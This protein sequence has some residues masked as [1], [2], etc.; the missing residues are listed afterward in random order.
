MPE[1][2][3]HYFE[4]DMQ[5]KNVAA[6]TN[7]KKNG[8]I[9]IQMPVWTP[10]SY[11]IREYPKNVEGFTATAGGKPVPHE[12]IRKNAWRVYTGDDNLTVHYRV[13]ANDLTVRTS[14]VDADH[15]YVTPA[16]MFMYHE[17]LKTIPLRLVVQPYK[18]WKNVATGLEPVAGQ[19]FTYEA[20]NY[21]ILVDSPLEIGNQKTFTF[22]AA[23]VP[24]TVAMFGEA[25]L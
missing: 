9:D 13:Y 8:Y 1:P 4:V 6:A 15:G 11:L 23:N 20:P 21:D 7:V 3:T 24:H 18:T 16:S 14:F 17:A 5:L 25:D 2:Q 22:T 19:A 12:K 10:G